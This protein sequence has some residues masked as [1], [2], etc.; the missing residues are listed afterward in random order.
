MFILKHFIILLGNAIWNNQSDLRWQLWKLRASIDGLSH[1]G[2]TPWT[3][4]VCPRS[5]KA[6]T[7]LTPSNEF[8]MR[9]FD[10]CARVTTYGE[11]R[12]KQ[13]EWR[14]EVANSKSLCCHFCLAIFYFYFNSKASFYLHLVWEMCA[15]LATLTCPLTL[16]AIPCNIEWCYFRF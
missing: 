11:R 13:N 12:W 3:W 10:L 2:R 4:L 7:N 6:E 8:W 1:F 14:T 15:R 16:S 5:S 9:V